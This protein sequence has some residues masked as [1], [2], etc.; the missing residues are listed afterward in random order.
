MKVL[1]FGWEYPPEISGGLAT[2]CHGLVQG[3]INVGHDV[4][5]VIPNTTK[6]LKTPQFQLISASHI[7]LPKKWSAKYVTLLNQAIYQIR[8]NSFQ[9]MKMDTYTFSGTYQENLLEEVYWLAVV[10]SQIALEVE[11]DII[12]AHDWLTYLAG[13][14]AKEVSGKPMVVHVHATEFDRSKN[15]NKQVF[16]I[17]QLGMQAADKVMTVSNLT[18]KTVIHNYH[19][20]SQ[21]VI[22]VYNG[23]I[24]KEQPS[25]LYKKLLKDKI[26]TFLGRITY[27]KG[28]EYFIEAAEK[29][30][31]KNKNVR[32]VMAGSGDLMNEMILKAASKGL[33]T[34]FHFTGFLKGNAVQ[35]MLKMTDIFVMPSVS[36]PFGITPLEA[37]YN[38]VPVIIS[39]QSGV[40]EVLPHVLKVD[41]WDTDN[42]ADVIHGLL[43]Y[44]ILGEMVK[45][46]SSRD[47]K[48]LTWEHTAIGVS[49][50]YKSIA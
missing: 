33:A 50:I 8:P 29:V 3:L 5:F 49:H 26:V 27:Q 39:K 44:K 10:A 1:M 31:K 24:Q 23:V 47:L 16:Q 6:E 22:T 14:L 25:P 34:K 30:L 43:N 2:A 7:K 9:N 36:E 37:I 13:I 41:Y 48:T 20:P 28:P 42:L 45:G 21:K 15:I 40:S 17:E 12:H 32:F 4:K 19:I 35:R 11:F 38:H 18:R 46:S